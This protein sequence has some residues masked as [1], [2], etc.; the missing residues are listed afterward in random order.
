MKETKII[1]K[2]LT[3]QEDDIKTITLLLIQ[4]N[5]WELMY[6]GKGLVSMKITMK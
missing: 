1:P 5:I 2:F 4:L 6:R 3:K